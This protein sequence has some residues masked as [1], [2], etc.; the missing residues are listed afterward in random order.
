MF[1]GLFDRL[2]KMWGGGEQGAKR[3]NTFR[4]LI[5]IGCLG[6]ALMILS[7]FFSVEREVPGDSSSADLKG[8]SVPA[9]AFG[10]KDMTMQDYEEMYESQLR[11]VLGKIVGVENVSVMVN[12]E[13]SE[14]TV[15]EKDRRETEQ[16]T[17]ESDKKG[18]TRKINE[19]TV[20]DKVVLYRTDEGEKPIVVKRIKPRVRGVL[21]VAEGAEDLKRK[22]LII[23]AVQRV[24]DV[25]VHRISVMPRG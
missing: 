20:E 22:A 11:D 3:V 2:E 13:S 25:P 6:A 7:S 18:G 19:H 8:D 23:E 9:A 14:E 5:L 12:L 15:V 17:E 1:K 10:N 4:W 24:L 21:I 16:V